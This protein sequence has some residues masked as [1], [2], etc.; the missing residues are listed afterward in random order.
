MFV[1]GDFRSLLPRHM[2][3][4]AMTLEWLALAHT[5]AETQLAKD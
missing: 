3:S 1:L 4:Q 5:R 2:P